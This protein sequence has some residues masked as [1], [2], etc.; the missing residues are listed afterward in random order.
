[1]Y[2][3]L[4]HILAWIFMAVVILG[5]IGLVVTMLR[6]LFYSLSEKKKDCGCTGNIPWWVWWSSTHHD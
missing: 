1:M 3:I 2:N 5:I 4:V 6:M